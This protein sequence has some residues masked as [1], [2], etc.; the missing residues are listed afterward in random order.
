M[1]KVIGKESVR[2]QIPDILHDES[3]FESGVPSCVFYPETIADLKVVL[4][5]ASAERQRVTLVGAQTGTTGGAVPEDGNWAI[6]FSAMNRI[7]KVSREEGKLPVVLCEPGVTL[8]EL[9]HF[10]RSP[11]DWKYAVEGSHLVEPGEFFYPP[12]PTE[13]TAQ[14]GG[15][16]ANNAS[17]ARSFRFGPTR[18]H[19]D[20]LVLVLA[21]GETATVRRGENPSGDGRWFSTD[22]G[23]RFMAPELPFVSPPIKNASGYFNAAAMDMVDLFIGS[24]GTLASFAAIGVRLQA[25]MKMLSGLSFFPSLGAAFDFADFLRGEK[26]IA[27]IEFFDGSSLRFIDRYRHRM[28]GALP[29][30]P[31]NAASAVLWEYIEGR[32]AAW[33]SQ[34]DKWET[35]LSRCGASLED[36]WSGFD[37]VEKE[38][39]RRF[40]HALPETVNG[41][42]AENRRSCPEIRK[43]GTDSAFPAD[44]F[45]GAYET[46]TRLVEESGLMSAA[47][48]HLGDYHIHVNL[49]PST[50]EELTTALAVYDECMSIAVENSGTVS[51]EHGVGKI[52]KKYLLKMYGQP[53]VDAMREVKRRLDPFGILNPGNLF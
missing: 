19:I 7:I 52:K 6:V 12:D 51:A 31:K 2:A 18:A 5:Q 3:R 8:Q 40:R 25:S 4:E 20:S 17:G 16:V 29:E 28:P 50:C 32:P 21:S 42:I 44:R 1:K 11:Q 26:Q 47:F 27:A 46:M 43:I 24:E 14:L 30:F 15:T 45:R 10:L 48:G 33:E 22:Q 36:T 13:M 53:A 49:I 23:T 37:D 34:I 35:A 39:L 41:L 9:D 38:R